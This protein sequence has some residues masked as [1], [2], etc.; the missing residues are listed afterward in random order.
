[1]QRKVFRVEQMF[2]D[3]RAAAR[4]KPAGVG[5]VEGRKAGHETGAGHAPAGGDIRRELERVHDMLARNHAEL[6]A[7]I[8]GNKSRRMARAAGELGAAVDGM[9]KATHNILQAAEAIDDSAKSLGAALKGDF[10]R[11]LAQDIQDC[12]VQVYE[13]CNFQDLAGQRIAKV[14]EIMLTLEEQLAAML[15]RCAALTCTPEEATAPE[16]ADNGLLNGPKLDGDPGH[17][18]QADID[19]IFS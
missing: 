16:P 5:A 8:G 12:T 9:E 17:A 3:R 13:A 15:A 6:G 10:E 2:G 1:M 4:A 19:A 18:S 14:I 7:L 11:G